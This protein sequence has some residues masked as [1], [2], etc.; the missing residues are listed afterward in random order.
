MRTTDRGALQRHPRAFF[1]RNGALVPPQKKC[2]PLSLLCSIRF[3]L[4]RAKLRGFHVLRDAPPQAVS[5]EFKAKSRPSSGSGR[6]IPQIWSVRRIPQ[7][8]ETMEVWQTAHYRQRAVWLAASEK[9]EKVRK[10]VRFFLP[11]LQGGRL[12]KDNARSFGKIFPF[13]SRRLCWEAS[14]QDQPTKSANTKASDQDQPE[15]AKNSH[16]IPTSY[17]AP[18]LTCHS[19]FREERPEEL[20]KKCVKNACVLHQLDELILERFISVHIWQ[21]YLEEFIWKNWSR[22]IWK[23]HRFTSSK[24]DYI[25]EWL[26]NILK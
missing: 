21:M 15:N 20:R 17:I 23:N 2:A 8:A 13:F 26:W 4:R 14:D 25:V 16:V 11:V 7:K 19:T 22:R 18:S 12:N 24:S 9:Q 1:H 10:A 6:R 5:R 3:C